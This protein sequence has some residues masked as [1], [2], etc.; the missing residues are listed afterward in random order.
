[1]KNLR[2]LSLV[3][4]FVIC[5]T[6]NVSSTSQVVLQP[7]EFV[8]RIADAALNENR[9][10][11]EQLLQA[12]SN[13][14]IDQQNQEGKTPLHALLDRTDADVATRH[15]VALL[16]FNP[17]VLIT[18]RDRKTPLH[19]AAEAIQG[20]Q[21]NAAAEAAAEAIPRY[22]RI[23][24]LL[25]TK[26][27]VDRLTPHE[28]HDPERDRNTT[29]E[30]YFTDLENRLSIVLE[31]PF[32]H[33]E[34]QNTLRWLQSRA[35]L[36][37]QT[38]QEFAKLLQAYIHVNNFN[39]DKETLGQF[40]I[41]MHLTTPVKDIINNKNLLQLAGDQQNTRLV[42]CICSR[43]YTPWTLLRLSKAPGTK[44]KDPMYDAL[45]YNDEIKRTIRTRYWSLCLFLLL[46]GGGAL[47]TVGFIFK[48]TLSAFL[49]SLLGSTV[50]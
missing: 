19:A 5:C 30:A 13:Y 36:N 9:T 49:G 35:P 25:V 44:W 27:L 12:N 24:Q 6:E 23:L 22:Q 20:Y 28:P 39:I 18:D 38:I 15:V 29:A 45:Q 8:Q 16:K 7:D 11:I 26:I 33:Q 2:L 40:D 14:S 10:Q 34:L 47:T 50:N 21:R 46:G 17:R 43:I 4:V 1:M 42:S 37:N 32:D 3:V 41:D 48:G 31:D